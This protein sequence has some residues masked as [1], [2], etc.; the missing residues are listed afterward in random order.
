M[1]SRG[2]LPVLIFLLLNFAALG[3]DRV[4]GVGGIERVTLCDN[5]YEDGRRAIRQLEQK[6]AGQKREIERIKNERTCEGL[7]A[8]FV[9][10]LAVMS[11]LSK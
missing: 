1:F 9:V 11:L 10:G 7:L 3:S 6:V 5:C 4:A 2:Y 8:G